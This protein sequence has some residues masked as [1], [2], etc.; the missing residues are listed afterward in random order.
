MNIIKEYKPPFSRFVKK[1][2]KPLKEAINTEVDVICENPTIGEMKVGDLAGMRTHKF[3][4]NTK[5]YIIAYYFT[6]IKEKIQ[7][8]NNLEEYTQVVKVKFYQIGSHENFY[9]D[10]KIYLK[11]DG[12]HK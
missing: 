10:L 11:S 1:Q 9:E 12:W 8:N 5:Q 3:K 4:F 6:I 7:N 2:N